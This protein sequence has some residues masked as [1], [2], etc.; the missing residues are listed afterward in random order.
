MD[1]TKQTLTGNRTAISRLA[2][3]LTFL[4]RV[5]LAVACVV[6]A[7]GWSYLTLF[8]LAWGR[9]SPLYSL[10]ILILLLGDVYL[11][12]S[13]YRAIKLPSFKTLTVT[14]LL[15]NLPVLAYTLFVFS[16]IEDRLHLQA[17]A[18]LVFLTI[19]LFLWLAYWFASSPTS[20]V[21]QFVTLGTVVVCLIAGSAAIKLQAIDPT[22]EARRLS[23]AA[24]QAGNSDEARRLFTKA[25]DQAARIENPYRRDEPLVLIAFYQA[26]AGFITDALETANQTSNDS[27]RTMAL[28]SVVRG[29]VEYGDW[30]G[31]VDTAKA[32]DAGGVL[33]MAFKD[34]SITYAEAGKSDEETKLMRFAERTADDAAFEDLRRW[35]F[36]YVATMQARLGLHDEA[37]ASARKTGIEYAP[38]HLGFVAIAENQSGYL[39]H[40][41]ASLLEAIDAVKALREEG[42]SRDSTLSELADRFAESGLYDEARLIAESIHSQS[43]KEILFRSMEY[44]RAGRTRP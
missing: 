5:L 36:G 44:K 9:Q 11:G 42:V 31:A 35:S 8:V 6:G 13:F 3:Q 14:G 33:F 24:V 25:K 17:L 30:S 29:Q 43:T 37:L 34:L 20:R 7:L 41:R 23:V 10:V 16:N 18:P 2:D 27:G 19:W 40:S 4:S 32:H 15:L 1:I 21:A 12:L 26:K 38:E 39:E 22:E 28:N